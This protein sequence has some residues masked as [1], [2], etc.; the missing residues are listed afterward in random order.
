ML[1]VKLKNTKSIIYSSVSQPVERIP[2]VELDVID[3]HK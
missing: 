1:S 2:L 3:R